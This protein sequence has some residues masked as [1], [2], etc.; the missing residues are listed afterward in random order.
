MPLSVWV[1]LRLPLLTHLW[2]TLRVSPPRSVALSVA[3]SL[4]LSVALSL[5]LSVALSVALS[6]AL[7]FLCPT[8]ALSEPGEVGNPEHS[9]NLQKPSNRVVP[10]SSRTESSV[11]PPSRP[12]SLESARCG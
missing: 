1:V 2:M 8:G 11:H 3:L 12:H 6:L 4:A 10:A 9:A 5:A 7:L